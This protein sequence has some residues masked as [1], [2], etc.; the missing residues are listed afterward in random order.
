MGSS[1]VPSDPLFP[2]NSNKENIWVKDNKM[3]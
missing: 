1:S 3:G 2:L